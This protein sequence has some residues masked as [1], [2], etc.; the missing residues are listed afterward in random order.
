MTGATNPTADGPDRDQGT[1]PVRQAVAEKLWNSLHRARDDPAA[2]GTLADVEDAVFRFY[3]PFARTLAAGHPAAAADPMGAEQA[4]ETGL[5][6]AVLGWQRPDC[7]DFWRFARMEIDG[8]LRILATTHKLKRGGS[9][10]GPGG[11]PWLP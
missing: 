1:N 8:Q 6:R 11:S 10:T 7:R 2:A 4:A 5:A 9:R 3:L